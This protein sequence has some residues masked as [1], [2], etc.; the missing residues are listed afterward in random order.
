[1]LADHQAA[2]AGRADLRLVGEDKRVRDDHVAL[3]PQ[4]RFVEVVP[5]LQ[6]DARLVGRAGPPRRQQ[7]FVVDEPA[8]IV[9]RRRRRLMGEVGRHGD[10]IAA[11]GRIVGPP[12]ERIDVQEALG[13][14]VDGIDRAAHVGA[15]QHDGLAHGRAR[16]G[17]RDR[18][19]AQNFPSRRPRNG[20]RQVM[21]VGDSDHGFRRRLG[22]LDHAHG[23]AED[24]LH[25]P[26]EVAGRLADRARLARI[27]QQRHV[28]VDHH[29]RARGQAKSS[30]Q[31]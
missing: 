21:R 20:C 27:D 8:A 16:P 3:E 2:L 4:Q 18:L 23:A 7:V 22:L 15:G 6:R 19:D 25:I 26:R 9:E 10:A 1:M 13:K 12:V 5:R 28:R 17:I 30:Q 24:R 14:L 11:G 31:R 29:L